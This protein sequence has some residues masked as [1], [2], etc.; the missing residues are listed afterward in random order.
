MG[1]AVANLA[2]DVALGALV[3]GLAASDQILNPVALDAIA[4][5]LE[6]DTLAAVP[7][8]LVA[9]LVGIALVLDAAGPLR[10]ARR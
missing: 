2:V 5:H 10:A 4:D 7:T 1:L 8:G 9:L 3:V 6:R